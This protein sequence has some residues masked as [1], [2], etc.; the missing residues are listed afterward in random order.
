MADKKT[1]TNDSRGRRL[2]RTNRIDAETRGDK[3]RKGESIS[4]VGA[5]FDQA[6][7]RDGLEHGRFRQYGPAQNAE[8]NEAKPHERRL[9]ELSALR[10]GGNRTARRFVTTRWRRQRAQVSEALNRAL[11]QSAVAHDA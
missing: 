2:Q 6:P 11:R 10:A 3:N 1:T 5:G 7:Q 8:G 4:G 9:I